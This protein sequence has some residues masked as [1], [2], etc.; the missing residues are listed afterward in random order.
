MD[1][2]DKIAQL[3]E[4]LDNEV[5]TSEEYLALK[6]EIVYTPQAIQEKNNKFGEISHKLKTIKDFIKRVFKGVI[7][8]IGHLDLITIRLLFSVWVTIT[9]ILMYLILPFMF[10]LISFGIDENSTGLIAFYVF[11]VL[12]SSI[13]VTAFIYNDTQ[14]YRRYIRACINTFHFI[15][16]GIPLFSITGGLIIFILF[17]QILNKMERSFFLKYDKKYFGEINS[18]ISLVNSFGLLEECDSSNTLKN[19][20]SECRLISKASKSLE[21]QRM[22]EGCNLKLNL[23]RVRK[24]CMK[25]NQSHLDDK[26][27][28]LYKQKFEEVLYEFD[29]NV[30]RGMDIK[31][32]SNER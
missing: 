19:L 16:V 18:R 8:F 15:I 4:M 17:T 6:E 12:L 20:R 21:Y 13:T 3:K 29:V 25:Q 32:R 14:K 1:K 31:Y 23:L 7:D 28:L 2:I 5:I 24:K 26:K 11:L 27:Y 22:S 30:L 10:I 9:L